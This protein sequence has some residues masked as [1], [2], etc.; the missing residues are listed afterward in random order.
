M[1]YFNWAVNTVAAV[2]LVD[3]IGFAAWIASGQVPTDGFYVGAITAHIIKYF[4]GV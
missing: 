1:K 4:F 2:L 3:G